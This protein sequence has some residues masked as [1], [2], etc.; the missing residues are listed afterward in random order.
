MTTGTCSSFF[1]LSERLR[2]GIVH[3]LGWRELTPVQELAIPPVLDG[4]NVLIL[5]PTAGG[6]TEAAVLPVLDRLSQ[7]GLGALYLSPLRALLNNQEPR[8][9]RLASLLGLTA[10][11][12]HSDVSASDKLRVRKEPGQLLMLTPES[13]EVLLTNRKGELF[14]DLRFVLVDEIHAFAGDDRGDHLVA[15]LE[16]LG[17]YSRHD[18]QRIGLSATVG[19]PEELQDWLQGGSRRERRLVCP[20][21]APSTRLI[22]V[23]PTQEPVLPA[24]RLAR[25]KKSLLFAESRGKVERARRALEEL[26]VPAFVHHASLSR[27]VREASE[28]AFRSQTECCIVCTRTMELG[29]D[30][31]DL[32]L[33][34]QLGA[35][36]SVSAF[37]QR[38]GRTGR[39][40]GTRGHLAFFTDERWEFLR[41]CALVTLAARGRVEPIALQRRSAHLFVQ[42]A[43]ARVLEHRGLPRAALE[44][45]AG[46]AACF[47]GLTAAD[48]RNLVQHLLDAGILVPADARLVLGRAGERAFGKAN[49]RELYSVFEAPRE[50]TVLSTDRRNLGT[51]EC[52]FA[53]VGGEQ[54]LC[55]LL[56]GE[57]WRAVRCDW[58]R[59]VLTV[60]PAPS[61]SVPSWSGDTR[62]IP[63]AV[64]EEVRALLIDSEPLAFLTDSAQELLESLRDEWAPRLAPAR[65]TSLGGSLYTFAGL[66]VNQAIAML[67][68]DEARADNLRVHGGDP[69]E[70]LDRIQKGERPA[71]NPTRLSKFQP[72]LPRDLEARFL[73]ERL[74]DVEGA[75]ELAAA[76]RATVLL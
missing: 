65:I 6:K 67:S 69:I 30:V 53:Q 2:G 54:P 37:L 35:P 10:F 28:Q 15:L 56:A 12:W 4:H 23:H 1:R 70:G 19:N 24:S 26:G 52:W 72:W 13:L 57:A 48:R 21:R 40:A 68:G 29:L 71:P 25:G 32:D 27:D 45:G 41:A 61:G 63:R 36:S 64:C 14:Q 73:E 11:K 60:E 43:V 38:L 59:G 31:G 75:R 39:R 5:A 44:E 51:L 49:F 47:A 3:R 34:L 46:P 20:P 8:L 74:L 18:L 76:S 66:R 42:Q 17:A 55:F 22:E 62:P 33:V 7:K 9:Q 50:L 16:R 58:D